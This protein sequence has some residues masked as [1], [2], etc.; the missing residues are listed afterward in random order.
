MKKVLLVLLIL[1]LVMCA[2]CMSKAGKSEN[3]SLNLLRKDVEFGMTKTEV[4]SVEGNKPDREGDSALWYDSVVLYFEDSRPYEA[5]L[6]FHF[7][8]ESGWLEFY[9]YTFLGDNE[10]AIDDMLLKDFGEPNE[11]HIDEDVTYRKWSLEKYYISIEMQKGE[12]CQVAV[13]KTM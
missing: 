6:Y 11:L 8:S 5:N 1:S 2:G 9:L 4:I 10:K 7:N 3:A 13:G 12:Q